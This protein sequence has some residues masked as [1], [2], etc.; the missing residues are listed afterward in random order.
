MAYIIYTEDGECHNVNDLFGVRY[1]DKFHFY[2]DVRIHRIDGPAVIETHGNDII[3]WWYI[4]DGKNHRLDGPAT[5]HNEKFYFFIDGEKCSFK[6][7]NK[8][9]DL[10]DEDIS[11]MFL[12]YSN[13]DC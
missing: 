13:M 9:A 8:K 6:N 10:S 2:S 5:L 12:K 1:F 11:I 7:F 4:V 3:S